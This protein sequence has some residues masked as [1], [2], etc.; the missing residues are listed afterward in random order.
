MA[1]GQAP[2]GPSASNLGTMRQ[3][4]ARTCLA[5]PKPMGM[6]AIMMG[7][8][9]DSLRHPIPH[10]TQFTTAL[11]PNCTHPDACRRSLLK[12]PR[13]ATVACL[14]AAQGPAG[15]HKACALKRRG[16]AHLDGDAAAYFCREP[17][18]A[19]AHERAKR[20]CHRCQ[21][22]GM[23]QGLPEVGGSAAHGGMSGQDLGRLGLRVTMAL[24]CASPGNGGVF[25]QG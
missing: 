17:V 6:A 24:T 1:R 22:P 8:G 4:D 21:P 14:R 15:L 19:A 16:S 20:W 9:G 5:P 7:P 2:Y 3:P 10:P 11:R 18:H 25:V 23:C 12:R 13:S